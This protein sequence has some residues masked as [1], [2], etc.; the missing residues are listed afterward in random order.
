MELSQYTKI[1]SQDIVT[2]PED[3]GIR[4]SKQLIKNLEPS[5]DMILFDMSSIKNLNA[6]GLG[7]LLRMHRSIT[8]SGKQLKM[9]NVA[10]RVMVFLELTQAHKIFEFIWDQHQNSEFA[11]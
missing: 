9:M 6:K 3:I 11:A 1:E 10:P 4:F 7:K 8:Q 5:R 2:I